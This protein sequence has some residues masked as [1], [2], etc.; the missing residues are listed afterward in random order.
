MALDEP[1]FDQAYR[2]HASRLRAVAFNVLHERETAE[3]AVHNALMRVW[4][5]GSY[6]ADRGPLLPFLIACVRREALDMVRGTKRRHL[7]EVKAV[8]DDPLSIDET[9]AIDPIETRRVQVA[10]DSLPDA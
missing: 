6:R 2:A 7:R 5:G 4:S 10:L 3:D 8:A 9:A 1:G